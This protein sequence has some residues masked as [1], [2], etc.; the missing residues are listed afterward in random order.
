MPQCL[1]SDMPPGSQGRV[2]RLQGQRGLRNRLATFG[3]VVGAQVTV[4][5]NHGTGP[6]L[7]RVHGTRIALGRHEAA[8]IWVEVPQ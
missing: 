4:L 1:L 5:Q 3:L 2:S 6:L 8:Q 7:V